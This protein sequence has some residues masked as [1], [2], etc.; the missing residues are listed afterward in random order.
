MVPFLGS[1]RIRLV[2]PFV[3][4]SYTL[5]SCRHL[6]S[7][8]ASLSVDGTGTLKNQNPCMASW[9]GVFL[10][11]FLSIAFSEYKCIFATGPSSGSLNSFLKLFYLF[12]IFPLCSFLLDSLLQKL[13]CFLFPPVCRF[14]FLCILC[15]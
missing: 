3:I 11:I 7:Y 15:C 9:P 1:F 13:F 6:L 4:H 8:R 2:F 10:D 12:S 14:V 5:A